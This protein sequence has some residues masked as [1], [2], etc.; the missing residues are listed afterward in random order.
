MVLANEAYFNLLVSTILFNM[1]FEFVLYSSRIKGNKCIL[2]F[3]YLTFVE[4]FFLDKKVETVNMF[5]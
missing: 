4:F 2:Q 5:A 3:S 1:Y